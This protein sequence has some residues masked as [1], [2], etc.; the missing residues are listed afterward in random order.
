MV[1]FPIEVDDG[2]LKEWITSGSR[3]ANGMRRD[4][5]PS[6]SDAGFLYL[7]I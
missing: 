7:S 6:P 4:E 2:C 3:G 5:Q 1:L